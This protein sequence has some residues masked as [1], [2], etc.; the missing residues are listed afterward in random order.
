MENNE[1]NEPDIITGD[2]TYTP[3][4]NQCPTC[5]KTFDSPQA[6]RM[7]VVRVHTEAGRKG[8]TGRARSR[9]EEERLA[10][11]RDYQ[12][13]LRQRYYKEGKNSKG[14]QMPPGWKPLKRRKPTRTVTTYK[15]SNAERDYAR[16]WYH[17]KRA[18]KKAA[19][20]EQTQ[21]IPQGVTFCPR[22]G[23]NIAVV[24]K[25]IAFADRQ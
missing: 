19:A 16:K 5:M 7:H 15:T 13:R 20:A 8:A 17:K 6:L 22:C 4:E 14:E 18:A 1:T 23:C 3:P 21:A 25:A 10:N 11:R 12:M 2:V 24:A 9:S